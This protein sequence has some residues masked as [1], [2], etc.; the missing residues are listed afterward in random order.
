MA[1]TGLEE[2]PG[3]PKA[4]SKGKGKG[5]W[6]GRRKEVGSA[7][8]GPS[9]SKEAASQVAETQAEP[10]ASWTEVVRHR[11]AP[12][13]QMTSAPPA[14]T[15]APEKPTAPVQPGKKGTPLP[16]LALPRSAAVI[17]KLRSEAAARGTTFG[18]ALLKAE[19]S[20]DFKELGIGIL[21]I[22][23]NGR[24]GSSAFSKSLFTPCM[25]T[26]VACIENSLN[27][28][29]PQI[30]EGIP[31]LG[32]E[33]SDPDF[34]KIIE[35]NVPN[36]KIQLFNTT[37]IGLKTCKLSNLRFNSDLTHLSTDINCPEGE[38]KATGQYDM[39][40]R[41]G[42]LHMEGNGDYEFFAGQFLLNLECE[43]EK[44]KRNDGKTQMFLKNYKFVAKPLTKIDF[45]FQNL[46]NG[47]EDLAEAVRKFARE[48]WKAIAELV[49][50]PIWDAAFTDVFKN[51]N[52][53]L[54][55]VTLEEVLIK[56]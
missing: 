56:Y 47:R 3:L 16:K 32:I 15:T 45:A 5:K 10:A 4:L 35:I 33:S 13:K 53:Y 37:L 44:V 28:A 8:F 21:R 55:N 51:I 11:S 38:L 42:T 23:Q 22:R 25:L 41:I 2:F 54:E 24:L 34:N 49:Q 27:T 30:F 7:A 12:K 43:I 18:A 17:P 29:L 31:K 19:T 39:K 46:F 6:K 36:L 1:Q 14:K 20:V 9:N 48:N 26:D 50:D 52:K 40:G